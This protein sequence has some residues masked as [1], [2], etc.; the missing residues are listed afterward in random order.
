[1]MAAA[2]ASRGELEN[3]IICKKTT[4]EPQNQALRQPYFSR[5]ALILMQ[6]SCQRRYG[7]AKAI[8]Y[9]AHLFP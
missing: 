5:V 3:F 7:W 4:I 9:Q 2:N 1:M 6:I 8:L